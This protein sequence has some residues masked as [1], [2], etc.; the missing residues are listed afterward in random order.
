MQAAPP[1]R[2]RGKSIFIEAMAKLEG[3]TAPTTRGLHTYVKEGEHTLFLQKRAKLF[4]P[5]DERTLALVRPGTTT[6]LERDG[7]VARAAHVLGVGGA[8]ELRVLGESAFASFDGSQWLVVGVKDGR[9]K[10]LG[11]VK[12]AAPD[13]HEFASKLAAFDPQKD[14]K[15]SVKALAKQA[16]TTFGWIEAKRPPDLPARP[17]GCEV[18]TREGR[19]ALS[20]DGVVPELDGPLT[21]CDHP[22]EIAFQLGCCADA[23]VEGDRAWLATPSQRVFSIDL[24]AGTG[25][26]ILESYRE[27]YYAS[28]NVVRVLRAAGTTAVVTQN[29]AL[30]FRDD[31]IVGHAHLGLDADFGL[32]GASDATLMGDMLLVAT[33]DYD[34]PDGSIRTFCLRHG[35]REWLQFHVP[36]YQAR[37]ARVDGRLLAYDAR[38]CL[39]LQREDQALA[40]L[41]AV[42]CPS[43]H[44]DDVPYAPEWKTWS[45]KG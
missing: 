4:A 1:L 27:P 33:S 32:Q 30:F 18:V 17:R 15:K 21:G 22:W 35:G 20:I 40:Y 34:R 6:L 10:L 43:G 26:V 44:G 45:L 36:L 2:G 11:R 8:S 14:W 23:A 37:F 41:D 38:G 31:Q 3:G 9:M 28:S 12:G 16:G 24:R 5:L 19:Y 13:L 39:E 25:R 42:M 7:G 29:E